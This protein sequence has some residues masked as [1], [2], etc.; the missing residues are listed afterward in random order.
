MSDEKKVVVIDADFFNKITEDRPDGELFKALM[1]DLSLEP[2]MHKYVYEKELF[3][4][5]TAQ[6]LVNAGY[7]M[8]QDE[9]SFWPT[10]ARSY[11]RAFESLYRQLNG[12]PFPTN[13]N[14][15]SYHHSRE[16]L[17]EIRSSL[18]AFFLGYDYFMS[19]DKAAKFYISSMLSGR[20]QLEVMNLFDAFKKVGE[21]PTHSI[22]WREIKGLLKQN[23]SSGNYDRIKHIWVL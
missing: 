4:N 6:M 17:G 14:I 16:S 10:D 18:L 21:L 20:H 5:T 7:I 12:K 3:A 11:I 9:T 1:D 2:L 15:L 22:K 19:D 8:I 23:L 13:E